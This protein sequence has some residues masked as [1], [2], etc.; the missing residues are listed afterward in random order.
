VFDKLRMTGYRLENRWRQNAVIFSMPSPVPNKTI[1]GGWITDG[2][3]LTGAN[4]LAAVGNYLFQAVMRRHLPWSEFGYLNATLSLILFAG[5]P[6]T[7]ASQTLTHHLAQIRALGDAEKIAQW[8]AASLKF[9]RYLTWALVVLFVLLLEPVSEYLRFPR[10]S[11]AWAGLLWLPV[12]LWSTLGGAWCTGLSRFRLLSLLMISATLVRLMTGTVAVSFYPWA[13]AGISASVFAGLVL[14]SIAV[15][16]P[17][18]AT[19]AS[20]RQVLRQ[21]DWLAYGGASLA[22]AFGAFVFLQGDQIIAQHHFPGE[23]LGRY[24]GAGLLGRTIVWAS[25]PILTVYFTHRSSHRHALPSLTRLLGIYLAMIATGALG[26]FLLRVPL[27]QLFLGIQDAEL[28]TLT[29]QFA[30][31]MI[32]IGILQAMGCHFLAARRLR[33]CLVFGGCGLAYLV[34]LS[35]FG[36]TPTLML[37][38]MAGGATA[39]VVLLALVSLARRAGNISPSNS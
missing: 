1:P 3:I 5:V 35:L 21:R 2:M 25:Y 20:L 8:Q 24:S 4:F 7:A 31:A 19:A 11:L 36:R 6:L 17:H 16:S 9:L 29:A 27:L 18:H 32:P 28:A 39:S 23:Q 14:A 38:W 37:D 30:L 22:M 26:I 33:E 15:F 10:M 34:A 13:E 12:N